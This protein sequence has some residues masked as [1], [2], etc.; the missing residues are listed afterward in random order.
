VI[1]GVHSEVGHV[2]GEVERTVRALTTDAAVRILRRAFEDAGVL[3]F[4]A[5]APTGADSANSASR[6]ADAIAAEPAES[7]ESLRFRGACELALKMLEQEHRRRRRHTS[8]LLGLSAIVLL[9]VVGLAVSSLV[10]R[11]STTLADG[12]AMLPC[13]ALG[14][15][16]AYAARMAECVREDLRTLAKVEFRR[17]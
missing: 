9:V 8:L 4:A 1:A 14:L 16:Y 3:P 6:L 10:W 5:G 12:L 7:F 15:W 2:K 17:P 13:G 11:E